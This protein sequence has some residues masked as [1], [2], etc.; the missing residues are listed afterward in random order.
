MRQ[1]ALRA[2]GALVLAFA[3]QPGWSQAAPR[4]EASPRA[5]AAPRGG[6]SRL[7][8]PSLSGSYLAG[9][10]AAASKD[11]EG[12]AGFLARA[13]QRED[14]NPALLARAFG[15]KVAAGD[16]TNAIELGQRVLRSDANDR[17]ARLVL[18]TRSVRDRRFRGAITTLRLGERGNVSDI[19]G[20]LIAA[21]AAQG[22]GDTDEAFAILNRL[23]GAEWYNIFRDFHAGLIAD[24]AGRRAEAGRRFAA[25]HRA[26]PNALRI[27]EAYARHLA[28]TNEKAR[29]LEVLDA[30]RA[31]VPNNPVVN[32]LHAEVS[33]DRPIAPLVRDVQRGAAEVLFGL[34]AALSRDGGDELAAIYLQLSLFLDPENGLALV[35]LADLF[36][37]MKRPAD[38]V[39]AYE[40]VP[41]TSPMKRTAEIQLA[42]ALDDLERTD[43][44]LAHLDQLLARN[45][46]DVE[47]HTTRG[48]ILRGKKRFEE[49]NQA[50]DR[51]LQLIGTPEPRHWTLLYFRGITYERTNRWAQAEA[52]FLK[53]L[54]FQPEQPL[55]LN[56]LGYSWVDQGLN[57][58][59]AM[60]MLKRAVELRPSDGYIIDSVGWAYYRIGRYEEAVNWLERAVEKKPADPVINDHLGDAYWRVGRQLEAYFQWRHARDLQPEPADLVRIERKLRDGL[61]DEVGPAVPAAEAPPPVA[62]QGG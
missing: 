17:L 46:D 47:V 54:E 11:L 27:V 15:L 7:L 35:T 43:E 30:F 5:D 61:V 33:G 25:A 60:A 16:M 31:R 38:V 10:T 6:P 2:A 23:R 28:R 36:D 14:R 48:N 26:D 9:R 8:L 21:W 56:Y 62:G 53:A 55:V 29:A 37:Q 39:R 3:I 51:A 58:E 18:A 12:A 49:A 44:A 50:Y 41:A 59:R 4:S 52:D 20:G 57:L 34:G 32:A 42:L 19:T 45:P 24:I 40:R 13:Q 22:A 1:N